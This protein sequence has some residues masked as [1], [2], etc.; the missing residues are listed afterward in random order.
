VGRGEAAVDH[1]GAGARAGEEDR[2]QVTVTALHGRGGCA[3]PP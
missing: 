1:G 3:P 2:L